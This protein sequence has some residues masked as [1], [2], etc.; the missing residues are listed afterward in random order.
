[1]SVV[2]VRKVLIVT[3]DLQASSGK[4]R[5]ICV[6]KRQGIIDESTPY[7][8]SAAKDSAHKRIVWSVHFC[9]S[10]PNILASGSRDGVV[11]VWRVCESTSDETT[12]E[13]IM[14]LVL[15]ITME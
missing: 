7:D 6:W 12:I 3:F 9:P 15:I 10:H 1:M 4:D 5:R 2:F 8:L 11:K 14:R 13:E